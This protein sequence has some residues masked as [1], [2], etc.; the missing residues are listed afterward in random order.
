MNAN[1]FTSYLIDD[2]DENIAAAEKL[3]MQTIFFENSVQLKRELIKK[4]LLVNE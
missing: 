4:R 3:G 1:T 2:S